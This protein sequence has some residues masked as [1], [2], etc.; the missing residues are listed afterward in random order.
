MFSMYESGP[1]N[2]YLGDKY[3]SIPSPSPSSS[4]PRIHHPIVGTH[5]RALYDQ[6][7]SVILSELDAQG[8]WIHR[9]HEALGHIFQTIPE[10]VEH[11]RKYFHKTNRVLMKQLQDSMD[12]VQQQQQGDDDHGNDGVADYYLLGPNFTAADICYVHCLDWSKTIGWHDKWTQDQCLAQ[13]LDRVRSRPA[14]QKVKSIR[15]LEQQK[16]AKSTPD[17][18]KI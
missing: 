18:S 14:Y 12:K 13:Y 8:L 11:A 1:I 2:T 16:Q 3:G 5:E 17:K 15:R 6:T 10:A 7:L 9:K 4:V